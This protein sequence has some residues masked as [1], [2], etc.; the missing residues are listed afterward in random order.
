M[1]LGHSPR[2][3]TSGLVLS[4]DAANP[5][6]IGTL[7]RNLLSN[8]ENFVSPWLT[9]GVTLT[10]NADISPSSAKDATLW[11][12]SNATNHRLY[13]ANVIATPCVLSIYVKKT[14]YRGFYIAGY[15]NGNAV[16]FD[17]DTG[18]VASTVGTGVTGYISSSQ[19][20]WYRCAAFLPAINNEVQFGFL[21]SSY[22]GG[23]SNSWS[24]STAIGTNGLIWGAQLEYGTSLSEYISPGSSRLTSYWKDLSGNNRDATLVGSLTFSNRYGG[25][26]NF[27]GA[28]Y[29]T[30]ANPLDQSTKNQEW[31]VCAWLTVDGTLNQI[32]L[33]L[34]NGL[35][36]VYGTNNS[37]L[38]L[39]GGVN[40]YYTYGSQ[41]N[42]LGWCYLTF[43]FRNSDGYRTIYKNAVNIS[44]SGPNAT[45]TPSGNPSVLT[46]AS[47][48][49]GSLATLEVYNRVLTDA[50]VLQN[51]NARRGRFG[52]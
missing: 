48:L 42:G 6:S 47:N 19:N 17:L 12:A 51:F 50:E 34:N 39:N 45:Y 41:V 37:L 44:T 43:R 14:Q 18:T 11:T 5:R 26:I 10:P 22:T 13:Q 36:P 3:V 20:G 29:A 23:L 21:D 46:I 52:I 32:L 38:Y 35:Y 25:I 2:S 16:Y 24:V 7:Y 40:D 31:T 8:P 33:N 30:V 4:L 15:N 49:R 9:Q 1:S 28:Q 27:T